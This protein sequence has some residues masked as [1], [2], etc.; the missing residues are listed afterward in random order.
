MKDT[1]KILLEGMEGTKQEMI[2]KGLWND[3]ITF[4]EWSTYAGQH[5]LITERKDDNA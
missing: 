4:E 1:S 2:E 5:V 3:N